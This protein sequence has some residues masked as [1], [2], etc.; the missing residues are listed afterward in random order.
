MEKI[1]KYNDSDEGIARKE[2]ILYAESVTYLELIK[3]RD[4]NNLIPGRFYRILDYVTTT[5]Q[6]ATT[7]AYH[8]FDIVLR[9]ETSSSLNEQGFAVSHNFD[10]IED[11]KDLDYFKDCNLAAWQIWYSLDNDTEYAWAHPY[12]N[13]GII[14]FSSDY[15]DIDTLLYRCP[16]MDGLCQEEEYK[17]AF[18]LKE[19]IPDGAQAFVYLN[20]EYPTSTSEWYYDGQD[21]ELDDESYIINDKIKDD[22]NNQYYFNGIIKKEDGSVFYKWSMNDSITCYTKTRLLPADGSVL[23]KIYTDVNSE[24]SVHNAYMTKISYGRG[25]IYRMIDEFDNDCGYDFKNIRFMRYNTNDTNHISPVVISNLRIHSTICNTDFRFY[26]D[27]YSSQRT[28]CYTFNNQNSSG[29]FSIPTYTGAPQSPDITVHMAPACT[30]CKVTSVYTSQNNKYTKCLPNVVINAETLSTK[31]HNIHIQDSQ[32]IS[33]TKCH[34][35]IKIINSANIY[36]WYISNYVN[37]IDSQYVSLHKLFRVELNEC[38]HVYDNFGSNYPINRNSTIILNTAEHVG[39]FQNLSEGTRT[40]Y[41]E[42]NSINTIT[43]N[44]ANIAKVNIFK[45]ENAEI[46]SPLVDGVIIGDF[47]FTGASVYYD[48]TA[49][50]NKLELLHEI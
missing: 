42:G 7:S 28:Y 35:N 30:H 44:Q 17:Y 50:A 13:I 6:D 48:L 49:L 5:S 1:F 4:T 33:I 11:D 3:L 37:I 19:N 45:V 41:L 10:V 18:G 20:T 21:G 47:Q 15:W 25:V 12:S 27:D 22:D 40:F 16:E 24:D 26:P 34:K 9:A 32:D 38:N 14:G 46:D 43:L 2:D 29:D 8:A 36:L 23:T 31:F 39:I